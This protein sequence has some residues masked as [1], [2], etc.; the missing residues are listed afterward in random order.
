MK[1]NPDCIREILLTIEN[2][3]GFKRTTVF[4]ADE[5][6]SPSKINYSMDEIAY[7]IRQ[8]LMSDLIF[9]VN[10]YDCGSNITVSDLT[11]KGHEFL[12]NIRSDKIWK[13]TKEIAHKIGSVSLN[14]LTSIASNVITELIKSHFGF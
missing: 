12:E 2:N 5:T 1:L 8:C 10:F 4:S 9:G 14:A 6:A 3:S 11:P 13:G 7:H